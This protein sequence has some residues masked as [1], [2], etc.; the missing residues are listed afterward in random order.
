[1]NYLDAY[2][3]AEETF[4]AICEHNRDIWDWDMLPGAFHFWE[5]LEFFYIEVF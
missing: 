4:G 1:M 3:Y 2:R 5:F